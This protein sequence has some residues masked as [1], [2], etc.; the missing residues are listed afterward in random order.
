VDLGAQ[1]H[2]A[3]GVG[4]L[5]LGVA[6]LVREP[7]RR[8]NRL[9]AALCGA[10]AVWNLG[11]AASILEV[12]ADLPWRLVF[13]FGSCAAA[14]IGLHF[15]L[16]VTG[17]AASWR[18]PALTIAYL[19]AAVLWLSSLRFHDV[20]PQWNLV[21]LAVLGS[22]LAVAIAVLGRHA[23]GLPPGPERRAFR[24]VF[25][26]SALAVVG[27]L[28]DFVPRG[29]LDVIKVGPVFMLA[30][31]LVVCSVV[32]RHRFL[33]VDVFLARAVALMAGAVGATLVLLAT[34]SLFGA[35]FIPLFIASLM[36][37]STM[38][39]LVRR[40]FTTAREFLGGEEQI[41]RALVATSQELSHAR[42]AAEV[43]AAIDD[44]RRV[45]P[46]DVH[47]VVYLGR[48]EGVFVPVYRAGLDAAPAEIPAGG[49]LP[50]M[51]AG[52]R[53]PITRRFLEVETREGAPA[54]HDLA[55]EA[56][57]HLEPV[58]GEM[59]VPLL[60]EDRL[61]GWIT[62]GGGDSERYVRS[63]VA[64]AFMAV[65][66]QALAS[67]ERINAQAEARRRETLAA[68]GEMAAGLAHEVR[69]P[70]AAIRG[71]AQAITPE[72]TP[73][74]SREMLEVIGEETERLGRVVGEFLDYARP[75][76]PRRERVDAGDLAKRV[77]RAAEL[78]GIGLRVEVQIS[79]DAA[80]VAGDTDQLHR[81]FENLVRNAAEAT[82]EGGTL[83]IEVTAGG[84]GRTEISFADDG[85]G[86]PDVVIPHL[87]QPF[88]T[89]KTGGTGL[90]LALV[91]RIVE[92]HG[93]S[94]RV[95][96]RPGRGA[97]F[98]LE[99]PR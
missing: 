30:F 10:L 44:G 88:H 36:L 13:L 52:E 14:P 64:A 84:E 27:G 79:P 72:A 37:L 62:V 20:Q 8:R 51:L 81:A 55:R 75:S 87:F 35:R 2:V 59:V 86:I 6:V 42:S 99:L 16:T 4:A 82:G 65:G 92:S 76:S 70:V 58:N 12:G 47:V 50:V 48:V 21:A 69:N 40:M 39:P 17:V 73:E 96:G 95:E 67:L 94:I 23:I 66:N 11:V 32:M 18:R 63:Q 38:G 46:G 34:A 19:A 93:G 83:R 43:W 68:V 80:P 5:G 90:G 49:G 3:A 60:G 89:T 45:L 71:A 57:G 61:V 25:G 1:L 31:L 97:V 41:A 28:S 29:D 33:D 22:I 56:L 91:H 98:T 85:P 26:A 78:S 7:R 77:A 53:G 54:G 15:V 24:V 74:Q 9:F